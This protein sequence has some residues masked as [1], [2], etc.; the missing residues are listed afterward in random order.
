[1]AE[2]GAKLA[3]CSKILHGA[4]EPHLLPRTQYRCGRLQDWK[5]SFLR[6]GRHGDKQR[7]VNG[8]ASPTKTAREAS[9]KQFAWVDTGRNPE[10]ET[11]PEASSF[12]L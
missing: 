10:P 5:R 11:E 9:W 4:L 7:V 6:F 1:M 8:R 12:S 3:E 2:T